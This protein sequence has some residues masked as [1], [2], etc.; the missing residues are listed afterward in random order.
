MKKHEKIYKEGGTNQN[1]SK[2]TNHLNTGVINNSYLPFDIDKD[3]QLIRERE[4]KKF[5][6]KIQ[7]FVAYVNECIKVDSKFHH[8]HIKQYARLIYTMEQR[9]LPTFIRVDL[10]LVGN[11]LSYI[12]SNIPSEYIHQIRCVGNCIIQC[13]FYVF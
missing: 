10:K 8:P 2:S 7:N 6:M 3:E 5:V 12:W 4:S 11:G 9:N 1:N 13:E